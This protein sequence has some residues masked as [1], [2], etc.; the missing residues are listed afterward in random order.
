MFVS[1]D[2]FSEGLSFLQNTHRKFFGSQRTKYKK[3]SPVYSEIDFKVSFLDQTKITARRVH[4]NVT[5]D[6]AYEDVRFHFAKFTSRNKTRL[7]CIQQCKIK[8]VDNI[9]RL[10]IFHIKNEKKNQT[11][12]LPLG[13]TRLFNLKNDKFNSILLNS[14]RSLSI[15]FSVASQRCQ[16][17]LLGWKIHD[18]S[19]LFY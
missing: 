3:M 13:A 18:C 12:F 7:L 10:N 6:M 4:I 17:L 14:Y 11:D 1:T 15:V 5:Y 2:C 8:N 9:Q 16:V 19:T